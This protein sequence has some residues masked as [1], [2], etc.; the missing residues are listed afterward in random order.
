MKTKVFQR[1]WTKRWGNIWNLYIMI[2]SI[3]NNFWISWE[4]AWLSLLRQ[5]IYSWLNR[6]AIWWRPL[7]NL[8]LDSRMTK[9]LRSKKDMWIM[10]FCLPLFGVSEQLFTKNTRIKSTNLLGIN[11]GI[12]WFLKAIMFM[13]FILTL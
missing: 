10:H 1:F 6:T 2:P 12:S 8:N 4:A 11:S 5:Q 9:R 13:D 3:F 7:W